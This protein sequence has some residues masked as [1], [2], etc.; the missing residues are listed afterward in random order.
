MLLKLLKEEFKAEAE[1]TRK[2]FDA[3]TDDVLDYSPNDFN[4]N[5]AELAS[6]MVEGFTWWE[7]TLNEDSIEMSNYRYDKGDISSIE[8]MKKRLDEYIAE[9]EAALEVFDEE[10]LFDPWSMTMNGEAIMPPTPRYTVIRTFLMN[11]LIHHRGEMISHLRA[12]SK[13]VP[14]LYGPTYEESQAQS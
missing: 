12:N 1:N 3:I 2:V 7:P 14:G 8:A 6:H 5:I 9:A 11:H 10:N 13:R 4:W